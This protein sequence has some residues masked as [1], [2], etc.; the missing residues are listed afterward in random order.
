[1]SILVNHDTKLITQGITGNA[2]LF[3]TVRCQDYGTN[4]MGGV[5]PR[6]P[7]TEIAAR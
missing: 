7:G 3:H 5:N 4:V 2:G 1:M 6:K